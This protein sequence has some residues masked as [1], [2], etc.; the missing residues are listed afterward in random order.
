MQ[1]SLKDG[2]LAGEI[3]WWFSY[4][5]NSLPNVQMSFELETLSTEECDQR[6]AFHFEPDRNLYTEAHLLL[7]F[8]LSQYCEE[9]PSRLKFKRGDFGRPEIDCLPCGPRLRFSLSHTKSLATCAVVIDDD[10]GVDAE[11]NVG[12]LFPEIGESF[13]P[14][15]QEDL[16]A[17]PLQAQTA[18]FLEYWTLK[19]S[20]LKARGLG[21]QIPLDSFWFAKK[22]DRWSLGCRPDIDSSP[23]SWRFVVLA[24]TSA[25]LAALAIRDD[26]QVTK[27]IRLVAFDRKQSSYS[28]APIGDGI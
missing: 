2:L 9:G 27:K 21:L 19:E 7:R 25:H 12:R 5:S 14:S 22:D 13:A 20:Y 16:K 18:R 26:G 28:I 11:N 3:H 23:D 6:R 1:Q 8:A 15:E 24:P 4:L 10:I 17:L